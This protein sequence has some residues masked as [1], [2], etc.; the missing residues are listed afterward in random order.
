MPSEPTAGAATAQAAGPRPTDQ[1]IVR[2]FQ[3]GD[4]A[5][6]NNLFNR[7][8]GQNR[9]PEEWQWKFA[10][11]RAAAGMAELA[12]NVA[13]LDGLVVG[14]FTSLG[15]RFKFFADEVM[16]GLSVDTA[17]DPPYRGGGRTI[18][19]LAQAHER[20]LAER[21]MLFGFG[22]PNPQHYAVGKLFLRYQDL[23]VLLTLRRRLN[24][25]HTL[26]R[27]VPWLPETLVTAAGLGAVALGR[28]GLHWPRRSGLIIR[29]VGRFDAA[30]DALWHRARDRYGILAVRDSRFLNWRYADRPGNPYVILQ[31]EVNGR[32]A[33]FIVL[34]VKCEGSDVVG[35][36]MDLFAESNP[37]VEQ[38]L[39]QRA[40]AWFRAEGADYAVCQVVA[41]G[42][43][44]AMFQ[45]AGFRE[46]GS[47]A[48]MQV[49][50]APHEHALRKYPD[51]ADPRQWHLGIGDFDAA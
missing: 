23:C 33:G 41:H 15:F 45:S 20:L 32:L 3:P 19:R 18:A 14:Q 40:L 28:I 24:C 38:A 34:H 12:I 39:L 43:D 1:L 37:A 44:A 10:G 9:L 47:F 48:P 35:Q 49:I 11:N 31:A 30:A 25:R 22:T 5:A 42:R 7:V 27:L 16:L 2:E 46:H 8:F 21:G 13:E 6:L 36:V 50:Y 51:L 26:R 29:R 4:E 17:V